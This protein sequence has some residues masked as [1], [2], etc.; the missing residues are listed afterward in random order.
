MKFIQQPALFFVWITLYENKI[1]FLSHDVRYNIYEDCPAYTC[2]LRGYLTFRDVV[3]F[4]EFLS[5]NV[6]QICKLISSDRLTVVTE[7]QVK[8]D[9]SLHATESLSIIYLNINFFLWKMFLFQDFFDYMCRFMRP[10]CHGYSMIWPIG[11]KKLTSCSNMCACL[12]SPRN[13]W[14]RRWR[15]SRW[16]RPAVGVRTSW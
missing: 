14:Y 16:W 13:T 7:E 5:L 10:C 6:D 8:G 3:H 1:L 9:N 2:S 11:N 4:D 15:R 12:W